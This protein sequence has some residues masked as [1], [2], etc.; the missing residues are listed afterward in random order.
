MAFTE[1]QVLEALT[2]N[3]SAAY[4]RGL[5]AVEPQWQQIASE[6]PSSGSSNFY[7]WLKDLPGIAEW[8]ADRQLK[9]MGSHGYAVENKTWESSIVIKRED[10]E[11]DNIG[12][13]A[14]VAEN[15]GKQIGLFPDSLSYSLLVAGFTTLCYDG[16]YFFDTD[17]PLE[18]TV[19]GV[20]SNVVGTP[21]TDVGSPWFL[22]DDTQVV[23][24]IIYQNRRPFVFQSMNESTEYA[25]FN[26]KFAAG[27]DG[28]CN[29]GFGFPQTAVGS[30]AALT[31][32]NYEAAKALMGGMKKTDGSPLGIRATK[33]V[34]GPANEAA[35]KKLI[36]RM[37]LA[38]GESNIYFNDVEVVVSRH[39]A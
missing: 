31:E 13:Y 4:T 30:K 15:Y 25:W 20:F 36:Q 32:A 18:T 17:H 23:K 38:N 35:A 7:G 11:D 28:R 6:I 2:V 39:I 29:V 10:V 5:G 16:Q 3:M 19:P 14:M 24:P 21:A 27:V 33:L 37:Q 9:E 26:N 22:I 1:A 12:K 8:V 34:V